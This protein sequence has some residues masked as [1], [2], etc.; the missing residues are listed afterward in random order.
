MSPSQKNPK[1]PAIRYTVDGSSEL[2]SSIDE[3]NRRVVEDLHKFISPDQIDALVLAGGYGRGEG[4]AYIVDGEQRLY[5]DLDYYL[6][7]KGNKRANE[8]T[9]GPR[10][11]AIEAARTPEAQCDV[12]FKIDSLSQLEKSSVS[13]FSYDLVARSIIVTGTEDVFQSCSRHL[14]ANAI[15]HSEATRLLFNRCSGLL[16]ARQR[17]N[18][19]LV[20]QDDLEFIQRNLAKIELAMGD[21]ILT[22]QGL[23]HWSCQERNRRL[24]DL[25]PVAGINSWTSLVHSHNKGIQFKLN[26]LH[27]HVS[28]ESLLEQL[29][30]LSLTARD[31]WFWVEQ[32]RLNEAISTPIEYAN[33]SKSRCPENPAWRNLLI[34]LRRS[35][36]SSLCK[37]HSLRYPREQLYRAM[38]LLLWEPN[39]WQNPSIRTLLGKLLRANHKSMD[40]LIRRYEEDWHI[41]G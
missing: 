11:K 32:R 21:A 39:A 38:G 15:P 41:F 34:N 6:F 3:V 36:I 26:P 27:P 8:K 31:V 24:Q 25:A 2:E 18:K 20:S 35:G 5:N 13:M 28:K 7:L 1:I 23:Y 14:D 12:E 9:F 37:P 17:L 19:E 33:H 40:E 10:I 16:F 29:M 4:G 22:I 30:Q